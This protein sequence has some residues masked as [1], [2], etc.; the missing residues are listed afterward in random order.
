MQLLMFDNSH[1]FMTRVRELGMGGRNNV[2]DESKIIE[3]NRTE[4]RVWVWDPWLR[5]GRIMRPFRGGEW[6]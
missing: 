1:F 5:L 4:F 6:S 3:Q 2:T